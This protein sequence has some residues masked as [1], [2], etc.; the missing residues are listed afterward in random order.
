MTETYPLELSET[1]EI[2]TGPRIIPDEAVADI[3][4]L[5]D[6]NA[7][8]ANG[9]RLSEWAAAA[10]NQQPDDYLKM[11]ERTF[12][13]T[14]LLGSCSTHLAAQLAGDIGIHRPRRLHEHNQSVTNVFMEAFA[15]QEPQDPRDRILPAMFSLQDIGKALCVATTGNNK[16]QHGHNL[17]V[18]R[19]LLPAIDES[20][21]S[22]D[23]KRVIDLL[24][25]QRYLGPALQ[26]ITKGAAVDEV[27]GF[28][29]RHIDTLRNQC[30]DDYRD[31]FDHQLYVSYMADAGAHTLRAYYMNAET[32]QLEADVTR[33][34]SR[35]HPG[36]PGGYT[37]DFLFEPAPR[38]LALK[39]PGHVALM[40][41]VFPDLEI[42]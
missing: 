28:A 30:P 2:F 10:S 1:L 11:A 4:E 9:D 18:A 19:N 39:H 40:H 12:E 13:N 15:P 37:L 25:D 34:Q 21:L 33:E 31:R 5:L 8:L 32:H 42:V 3:K 6:K 16:G 27:A 29:K 36:H 7:P 24:V 20:V 35:R 38:P 17:R 41:Q 26:Q 23:E 22:L 14:I